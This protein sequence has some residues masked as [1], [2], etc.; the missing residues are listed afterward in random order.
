MFCFKVCPMKTGKTQALLK[1]PK[2]SGLEKS[3]IRLPGVA[4]ETRFK[5]VLRVLKI[6]PDCT[7]ARSCTR[8]SVSH[9]LKQR[10]T[11]KR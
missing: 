5:S 11:A 1:E 9:L 4:C 3:S 8:E 2:T 7:A 6:V 10:H